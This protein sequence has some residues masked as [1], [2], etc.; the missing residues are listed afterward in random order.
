MAVGRLLPRHGSCRQAVR[1]AEPKPN[2]SARP[3]PA[4]TPD[5]LAGSD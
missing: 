3:R 4:T 2:N 5:A 1:Q